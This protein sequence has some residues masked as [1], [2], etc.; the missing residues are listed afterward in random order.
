MTESY[1]NRIVS[2]NRRLGL[3]TKFIQDENILGYALNDTIYLND[4]IDNDLYKTNLHELLHFY[5]ENEMFIAYKNIILDQ[6]EMYVP[7]LR[8]QYALRYAGLYSEEEIK[9]GI[10]DNE[11]VIDFLVDE[12]KSDYEVDL[13][14]NLRLGNMVLKAIKNNLRD[15][16]YLVLTVRS[17][18]K[19]M[20]LSKWDKIFAE[21]YYGSYDLFGELHNYPST[22]KDEIIKED[23]KKALDKLYNLQPDDFKIDPR[24]EDVL[25]YYNN[26]AK[27]LISRGI[28]TDRFLEN[29]DAYLYE[30]ASKFSKQIYDEYK[31]V[32]N[33]I[34][35]SSY[36]DSFKYLMLNETLTKAYK[37][38]EGSKTI[39]KKRNLHRT[40]QGLM[41]FNNSILDTIYNYSNENGFSN[42]YF[43][44]LEIYNNTIADNNE[45]SIDNLE[46]YGKGTWIKFEG[47]G[48]NN[49]EYIK[50][51]YDLSSLISKTQWC[52]KLTASTALADGDFYIFIDND[53]KPHIAVKMKGNTIDEVR[54]ISGGSNQELEDDYRDVAVSFL[55]NN[56]SIENGKEWLQKEEWNR[57]LV[58]YKN[59]IQNNN[60]DDINIDEL[61]SDLEHI[62]YKAH[63]SSNSVLD[64]LWR[65]IESCPQL[66]DKIRE[67][68]GYKEDEFVFEL[69]EN[70]PN[71]ENIKMCFNVNLRRNKTIKALP[72][73]EVIIHRGDF[74]GSEIMGMPF[75]RE[76]GEDIY[77][78]DS[79]IENLQSLKVVG[80]TLDLEDSMIS[81]IN[82]LEKVGK[83]IILTH[84]Y[85]IKSIPNL[86]VVGRD[87][88][89]DDT[90]IENLPKLVDIRGDGYFRHSVIENFDSIKS[91]SGDTDFKYAKT[92]SLNN[93]TYVG[94]TLDL[95]GS[96]ILSLPELKLVKYN[97]VLNRTEIDNIPNLEV[98]EKTIEG[99]DSKIRTLPKLMKAKE[100]FFRNSNL[101]ELPSLD[102][103]GVI[104]DIRNT[105]MER[106]MENG[107]RKKV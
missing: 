23:I 60:L 25:R 83:D 75:L 45:V 32:L 94:G 18:I 89:F 65:L 21:N 76:V 38:D 30:I 86:E 73:L 46:T 29:K 101:E 55:M 69:D 24:S 102:M 78:D 92:K 5:E 31:H 43:A 27:A 105:P 39:V 36:D 71:L 42:I 61:M 11:I 28:Y 77:F 15:K 90:Y 68:Y 62:D 54:G 51:A 16:R 9:D 106:N 47:K 1:K 97:L 50:N 40:I 17:N 81:N 99:T 58:S 107:K 56:T 14:N 103:T 6:I 10:I 8:E 44:A 4:S 70:T 33:I 3:K 37:I 34:K 35:N 82:S 104:L 91:I 67:H 13:D 26:T 19:A 57:R 95:S 74:R 59:N 80:G 72:N 93:L 41:T 22:N 53:N 85:D 64:G 66:V 84:T 20:K 52:T 49:D 87:A 79:Y 88:Y 7:E 48:T 63:S 2:L 100:V 12:Y 98:V 96:S